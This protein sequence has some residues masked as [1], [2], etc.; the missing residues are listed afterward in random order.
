MG[1]RR[2]LP[3]GPQAQHHL[4]AGL[5]SGLWARGLD[6]STGGQRLSWRM[7]QAPL[8]L[9]WLELAV[10]AVAKSVGSLASPAGRNP[11]WTSLTHEGHENPWCRAEIG[12]CQV[13]GTNAHPGVNAGLGTVSTCSQCA[14]LVTCLPA[15]APRGMARLDLIS[16]YRQGWRSLQGMGWAGL[17][18]TSRYRQGW[19]SL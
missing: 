16:R 4:D 13:V 12:L 10:L 8:T 19:R 9:T 7:D 2:P 6:P 3:P 11:G 15:P 18:V 17:E 5:L 1:T 14:G